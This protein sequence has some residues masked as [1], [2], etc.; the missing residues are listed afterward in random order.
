M[1]APTSSADTPTTSTVS[2]TASPAARP[3]GT[4]ARGQQAGHTAVPAAPRASS[5]QGYHPTV[6]ARPSF[7]FAIRAEIAKLFSLRGTWIYA[8]LL[9]GA[10]YGPA[11]LY[12]VLVPQD[13][14]G[15]SPMSWSQMLSGFLIFLCIAVIQ[16]GA[17]TAASLSQGMTVHAFLTQRT[18]SHWLLAQAVVL[19]V[20]FTALFAVGAG[21]ALAVCVG[22]G[23]SELSVLGEAGRPLG[24]QVLGTLSLCTVAMG[25]GAITR[26]RIIAV[27]VPLVWMLVVESLIV[28]ASSKLAFLERIV[29]ILPMRTVVGG[30]NGDLAFGGEFNVTKGVLVLVTWAVAFAVAGLLSNQKRDAV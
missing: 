13:A 3:A 12:A 18:R 15:D 29:P 22:S 4:P 21:L 16:A 17:H 19:S 14:R 25:L 1:N 9:T 23:L 11:V 27:A 5:T 20:W 2:P 8:T 30:V 26:S 24:F 10:L 28:T 6:A 7:L